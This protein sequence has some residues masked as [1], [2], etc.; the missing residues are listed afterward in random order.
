[1]F[2]RKTLLNK[3]IPNGS[4]GAAA[5]AALDKDE[6]RRMRIDELL[7]KVVLLINV[8]LLGGKLVAAI[9]SHSLSIVS[10]VIDSAVDI[11]SGLVIW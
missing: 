8:A 7:A 5:T 2:L 3:N 11:T 1:V 6:K 4:S 10:T 9:M